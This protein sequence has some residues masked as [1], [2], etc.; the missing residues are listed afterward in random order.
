MSDDK[1]ALSES[2]K[3]Y[4]R[5]AY[6]RDVSDEDWM[7][8]RWQMSHRLN[9][10]EEL[11]NVINLTK[12]E[13]KALEKKGLFRVDITPYFASLI[14]PD[15]PLCPVR[16]QVIPTSQEVVPFQSMMEDSLAEDKHSPVPGLVHR[17]PDRVLMLVTTQCASYCRY[18]TRSRIVGDP[19]QTF[20]RK[21]FDAQIEYI[22]NTPQIR[23]VLLSGGDPMVLAPKLLDMILSRLRDIP[24]VEIIRIGSRVPVFLPMRVTDEFCQMISK[25]HPFWLNIHVNHPKEITPE[26]AEAC[27]RLLKAGVPL[28]NQSVL[29]AGVNDSVH[30]QRK[31]VHELV[32]IRVR[33]YYL[34]QCDLVAGSGHFRTT[35]SKGIEIMEGLRGHTSGYSIPAYV[36]DAPGGGGKIPIMPNYVLAQAPGKVVL[37]NFEGFITTYEEPIDYDP[38]EIKHLESQIERRPEPGQEGLLELLE[39]ERLTIEPQG[40]DVVRARGGKEHRLRSGELAHK[41]QPLGV[42]TIKPDEDEPAQLPDP[43]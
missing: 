15:D 23:D 13:K 35:I 30:I 34:Y 21:E 11:G 18:C 3:V 20:S 4:T 26:L 42:G 17:Y 1:I 39:G 24:H 27:D 14:D 6:W 16:K 22:E 25:Y 7:D 31:L 41:W 43:D 5:A 36:V 8:W 12:S 29:L 40:F 33:P 38:H 2:R 32:K 28:G 10:L 37:R 9:T 19:S